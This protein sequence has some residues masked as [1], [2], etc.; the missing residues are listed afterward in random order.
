VGNF[1]AFGAA[2]ADA[3]PTGE[4]VRGGKRCRGGAHFGDD[5]AGRFQA[6]SRHFG[7]AQDGVA[8]GVHGFG[9]QLLQPFDVFIQ[10]RQALQIKRQQLLVQRLD[11]SAE[12]LLELLLAT[13]QAAIAEFGQLGGI[14]LPFGD[15]LKNATAA[16]AEQI[17]QHAGQFDGG[18]FEQSFDLRLQPHAVAHQLLAHARGGAP[19]ALFRRGHETED[20]LAGHEAAQQAAGRFPVLRGGFHDDLFDAACLQPAGEL[21]Q[22]VARGLSG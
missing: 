2:W 9:G 3:G 5:L 16:Q 18:L 6:Q 14:G 19:G 10:Q 4:A 17:A 11:A 21:F 20:Q 7:Q 22:L 15:G 12:S 8:L 13:A 1:G